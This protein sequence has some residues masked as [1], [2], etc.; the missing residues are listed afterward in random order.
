MYNRTV[1]SSFSSTMWSW[2]TLS[3]KVRGCCTADGMMVC[4]AI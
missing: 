1:P 4:S 3:Y 2:K